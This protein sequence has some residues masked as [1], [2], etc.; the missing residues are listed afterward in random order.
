[1]KRYLA[2]F[3][4]LVMVITSV[5]VTGMTTY[6]EELSGEQETIQHETEEEMESSSQD[7]S[8][9]ETNENMESSSSLEDD[10]AEEITKEIDLETENTYSEETITEDILKEENVEKE[11]ENS[12]VEIETIIEKES[13]ES[14][15][16]S[17]DIEGDVSVEKEIEDSANG[18]EILEDE[19]NEQEKE[20]V[21]DKNTIEEESNIADI[22]IEE[23]DPVGDGAT[24]KPL[25][26]LTGNKR[27][28]A[29]NIA[30][31]Q[32]GY[33]EGS[34]N[35]N[36][37]GPQG[38]WCVYFARWCAM[39]AGLDSSKWLYTGSTT[40]LIKWFKEQG[41]WHDKVSYTW[42]YNGINGG[43]NI[44]NYVPQPGDFAAIE[45]NYNASDGPGHTGI[46][47]SVDSNY[48]YV[49]EG[50]ISDQVVYRQ[51]KRSDL[52][53]S[54]SGS[55]HVSIVGFGE[56]DYGGQRPMA[57]L[58]GVEGGE[59]TLR[60]TGWAFDFDDPS[61]Q[62]DIHVYV[63]GNSLSGAE[64][65]VIKANVERIDVNAAY[66]VGN[67]HGFDA[68]FKVNAR[69]NQ[70]IYVYAIDT[71]NNWIEN[72]LIDK[73]TANIKNI[74]FSITYNDSQIET[75]VGE[76]FNFGF[77]FKGDGIDT[78]GY[79]MDDLSILN[80]DGFVELDWTK[81]VTT[82]QATAL[83]KGE[84]TLYMHLLDKDR[85]VL[86]S[87]G[88]PVTVK[89][90]QPYS[91]TFEDDIISAIS[92]EV[93]EI[94]FSFTGDEIYTLS[95]KFNNASMGRVE[96]LKN[97][98][99]EKGTATFK[100][101]MLNPG[102]PQF[103]VSLLDKNNNVLYTD[104]VQFSITQPVTGVSLN[105]SSTTLEVGKT[106]TLIATI[107]PANSVSKGITW[108]SS[109]T[110]V[111]TVSDGSVSGGT[112]TAKAP[113]TATIT[114]R[115]I[116]GG[117]TASCTV[118]VTQPV[119]GVSLNK[120]NTTLKVGETETLTTMVS[121]TTASNKGVSW[122][123]SNTSVA[124]VSNGTITAKSSGTATITVRTN[125]GGYTA[126][127]SVTVTEA[128]PEKVS[129]TGIRL[130][131]TSTTIEA[132][133]TETL[134]ATVLPTNATNK[135]VLWAS[136]NTNVATVLNG[137]V[138]AK[139]AGTTTITAMTGQGY[140]M[141]SCS[142]TVTE[143]ERETEEKTEEETESQTEEKT[144]EETES[145][146][147]EKTE[148]ETES[149]TEEKTE[150]ETERET[151]EKTEEETEGE[152]EQ[153]S[154]EEVIPV[155]EIVF[156]NITL[157]MEKGEEQTLNYSVIPSNA[158][159]S[160]IIFAT[161]DEAVV[162]VDE[163]GKVRANAVGEADIIA[164]NISSGVTA[165]CN[166]TV[167]SNDI[168]EDE[169]FTAPKGVWIT[170][171]QTPVSYDGSAITQNIKVYY[172]NTILREKSEYTIS[173]KNNKNVGTA[174]I[175]VNGKGNYSGKAV[176]TF[177]IEAIDLGKNENVSISVATA[178]ETGERLKPK[179]VVTWNGKKLKENKDYILSH[180]LNII[181]A[182]DKGY[183]VTI[184]GIGNYTGSVKTKFFVENK[185]K[186]LLN[187][188]TVSGI[189][190]KYMYDDGAAVGPE[191]DYITVKIGNNI[192]VKDEDYTIRLD[193][194]NCVGKGAVII[195]AVK[196][197]SYAG[198]K[199]VEFNIVGTDLKKGSIE[200]LNKNY[201]YTGEPIIPD[202]YV[203]TGKNGQGT[204]LSPNAYT[205]KCNNNVSQGT[206]TITVTGI[207][208]MGVSGKTTAKFK[209]Q[210][211]NLNSSSISISMPK[212][213]KYAKGGAKPKP[214]ISYSYNGNKMTLR[215]GVDY[216]LKYSN[217]TSIN[218]S[219][220][221]TVK[222]SGI[223]NFTGSVTEVF[224]IDK[225]NIGELDILATDKAYKAQ[226]KASY[227]CVAPKIYDKDGK[228]LKNNLD[229]TVKYI[230]KATGESINSNDIIYN[231]TEICVIATGRGNY[232]G[233]LSTSYFVRN[234][235]DINKAKCDKIAKQQY[236][237]SEITPDIRMYVKNG[238]GKIYLT[239]GKDY[240]IVGYY[241]NIKKGTASILIKGIGKYSGSKMI[242][243][244]I[245][246]A[247]ND[248]IWKG[249]FG[250]MKQ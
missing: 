48:V 232:S 73:K 111:A 205:I 141:T 85:N 88:I 1:M 117:Y 201:V 6:A 248:R 211:L 230:D 198:E 239:K 51:Y 195:E 181:K 108:T 160:S 28:D 167:V 106:E 80:L 212:Q 49:V 34:N 116:D 107:F 3:L 125:D 59:G 173:Y 40:Q 56:P 126:S 184:K 84:T 102:L 161:S 60:V 177:D 250:G 135:T 13:E 138:T 82:I 68:T 186:V 105:K 122:T 196:G 86:Y 227:Y 31:S 50:N 178:V 44:D 75:K 42:S 55:E 152:T 121:P 174:Q 94:D 240:Q 29:A 46:V 200:V 166:I 110:S 244:K 65:H 221:P 62:L 134:I 66:G 113:G 43:G 150:E 247:N 164:A 63:G 58:E 162:S 20:K 12:S 169:D 90:S 216:S 22:I 64:A 37:Y 159:D 185:G 194:N 72:I 145:Q 225:Q 67:Y 26:S 144:E 96:E 206:A 151:E 81:G 136:S 155:T 176:G 156:E 209:I 249:I 233:T 180:N 190:K 231:G 137:T 191:L 124:T 17:E 171:V 203:F 223:G 224:D 33:K 163:N 14:T 74:P 170:G 146:T 234:M 188:A 104:G 115:T 69:G 168:S 45:N 202:I 183:D 24:Y 189:A 61:A 237:G 241:N 236:T 78:I 165:V 79:T 158:T 218:G 93:I 9:I 182:S 109:N 226:K 91:I 172:G 130:N 220:T 70:D 208:E 197:G 16:E 57:I 222:I 153:E 245:V 38:Q 213:I 243:F 114:V 242:T 87:K 54:E 120:S 235:N 39:Q 71:P 238:G 157:Q 147:E 97:V 112:I 41:R 101:T 179:A 133:N 228:I 100:V 15:K 30:Y 214:D 95:G 47:Y 192:L 53:C 36:A 83:K 18:T 77:D 131:K 207:E 2:T 175:I 11:S 98:D 204:V 217:N 7:E 143:T 92:G 5:N 219:G 215:E 199:R 127:C 118:T 229:Y 149:Q 76:T 21:L 27:I 123:S 32:V 246:A 142:V 8:K 128:E 187:K 119:T 148:E 139:S 193:S 23:V 19:E 52:Y 132:G 103:Y 10:Y 4:A 25:P 89:S 140:Y 35:L 154:K 99:L 210:K 129:V